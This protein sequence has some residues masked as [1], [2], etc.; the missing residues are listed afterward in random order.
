[1]DFIWAVAARF[2]ILF[3]FLAIPAVGIYAVG[4]GLNRVY[5]RALGYRRAIYLTGWI[6]TPVHELSHALMALLFGFR[7]QKIQLFRPESDGTLGSVSYTLRGPGYIQEAGKFL[8]GLA[9]FLGGS[10]AIYILLRI[11]VPDSAYLV[12]YG[13]NH[14]ISSATGSFLDTLVSILMALVWSF[15]LLFEKLE[16]LNWRHLLFFYLALAISAHMAPSRHDL[17]HCRTGLFACC[18]VALAMAILSAMISGSGIDAATALFR[19]LIAVPSTLLTISLSMGLIVLCVSWVGDKV[20][21]SI[22]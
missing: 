12:L 5:I 11:L 3:G 7:L 20:S 9:P 17:G 2:M 4:A 13:T 15:R 6:G 22:F 19:N 18:L 14:I 21:K 16:F 10:C 1:M 8:V